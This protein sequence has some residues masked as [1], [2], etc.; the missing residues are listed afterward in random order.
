M[1]AVRLVLILMAFIATAT[2]AAA[3]NEECVVPARQGGGFDLTC[4]LVLALADETGGMRITYM[5]GG[6]GA[7][8]YNM[9][10]AQRRDESGTLVAFSGGRC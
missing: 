4:R 2:R 1:K 5:P 10:V 3:A 7:V 9:I 6:V 8:A